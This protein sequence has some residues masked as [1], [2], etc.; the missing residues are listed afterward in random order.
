[1]AEREQQIQEAMKK[2]LQDIIEDNRKHPPKVTRPKCNDCQKMFS[3]TLRCKLYQE[4]IPMEILKNK[5]ECKEFLQ[6]E[7]TK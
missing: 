7:K 4:G 5:E 2:V 1:M 3:E 6:K